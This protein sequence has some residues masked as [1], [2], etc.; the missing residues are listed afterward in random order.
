[1]ARVARA[2]VTLFGGKR[3]RI[4]R[5]FQPAREAGWAA[6]EG[7]M[8]QAESRAPKVHPLVWRGLLLLAV[9][10]THPGCSSF[11]ML[12]LQHEKTEKTADAGPKPPSK[13]SFRVAPYVFQSD[14][15]LK[16]DQPLF[17]ELALLRDQVYKEL[18]LTG[19]NA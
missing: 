13:Y 12:V 9:I 18:Q 16:R 1:S 3:G 8:S 15:E 5:L 2:K 6:R 19:G 14:F 7:F 4:V 17:Q 10:A 11:R